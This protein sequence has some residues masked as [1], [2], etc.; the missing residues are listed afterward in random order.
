MA[1]EPHRIPTSSFSN[2]PSAS[3]FFLVALNEATE[4]AVRHERNR[5]FVV[6]PDED[7]RGRLRITIPSGPASGSEITLGCGDADVYL[8]GVESADISGIHCSF[9]AAKHTG[10]VI[11]HD[12]S[13][14]HN[15][16]VYDAERFYS[17]PLFKTSFSV[18]VSRG[19]NR[20]LGIG[21]KIGCKRYYEFELV[22][23]TDLVQGNLLDGATRGPVF[24][25]LGSKEPRY[26]KGENLGLGAFGSVFRAVDI[27]NGELMAVKRFHTL[28]GI[29]GTYAM[30]EIQNLESI[31]SRAKHVSPRAP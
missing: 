7:K 22:W 9:T 23:H 2:A 19:F 10:A 4:G 26:I 30:R 27:R 12:R 3:S 15:T 5:R 21:C 11:L 8:P 17:I 16:E 24:G 28:E 25:P 1:G 14:Q 29:A 13:S 31:Q 6:P 20:R 18:V